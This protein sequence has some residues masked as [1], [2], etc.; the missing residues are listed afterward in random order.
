MNQTKFR[1]A[2]RP[3]LLNLPVR[4][5]EELDTRAN[6]LDLTRSDVMRQL[7]NKGLREPNTAENPI[8]N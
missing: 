1:E 5:I 7:L 3:V 8:R 6:L 2:F 4:V